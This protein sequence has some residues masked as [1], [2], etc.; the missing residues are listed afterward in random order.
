MLLVL[1]GK[2]SNMKIESIR[3]LVKHSWLRYDD[4]VH[5]SP[6]I[7]YAD[8]RKFLIYKMKNGGMATRQYYMNM[9]NLTE[10]DLE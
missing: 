5:C 9:F 7:R 4:V 10:E 1:R 6:Y 2:Q 3:E 8:L